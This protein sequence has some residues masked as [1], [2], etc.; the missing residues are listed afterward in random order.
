MIS[1][2]VHQKNIHEKQGFQKCK[3]LHLKKWLLLKGVISAKI[4]VS[5]KKNDFLGFH[6][7]GWLPL[8]W[9]VSTENGLD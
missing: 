2:E 6:K 1:N 5:T 7:T 8:K 4:I 9:I 3:I